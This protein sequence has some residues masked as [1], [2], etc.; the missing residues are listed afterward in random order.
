MLVWGGGTLFVDAHGKLVCIYT[1]PMDPLGY[2]EIWKETSAIPL[3]ASGKPAVVAPLFRD[4][5][6]LSPK[7]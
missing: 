5:K 4:I 7:Q 3:D 2:E 6:T 1:S